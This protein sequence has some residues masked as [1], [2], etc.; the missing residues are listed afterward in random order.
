V[1]ERLRDR[2]PQAA[3]LLETATEDILACMPCPAE[4]GRPIDSTH[5]LER[6]NKAMGRRTDVVGIF[7]HLKLSTA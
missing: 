1:A 2:Y 5:P 6:L 4:H 7:P 3:E